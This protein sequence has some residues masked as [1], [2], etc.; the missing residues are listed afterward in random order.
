MEED[1]R[2]TPITLRKQFL[3]CNILECEV[4]TNTPQGGDAG[5]G[6]RTIFTLRDLGSTGWELEVK[7]RNGK[8]FEIEPE[9]ITIKLFGDTEAYTFIDALKF[10]YKTLAFQQESEVIKEW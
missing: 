9:E 1:I 6:G 8:E 7:D 5:H 4:G 3:S 2:H 10:A